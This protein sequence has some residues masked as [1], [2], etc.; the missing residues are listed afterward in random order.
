MNAGVGADGHETEK[1]VYLMPF[2]TAT[3]RKFVPVPSK[4][5]G[6]SNPLKFEITPSG[7]LAGIWLAIRGNIAGTLSNPNALGKASI[8]RQVRGFVNTGVDLFQ[9]SGPGYHYL[10]RNHIEDYKDPVPSSDGRSAVAAGD[11]NLDMFIPIALSAID[12]RGLLNLQSDELV[13]T[14][15]VEFEADANIATGITGHTCTVTPYLEIFTMPPDREDRPPFNTVQQII[16]E[17]RVVSAAGD[18]PYKWPTGN[19]YLQLLLGLGFGVSGADDWSKIIV[20]AQQTDRMYE[21]D[22]KGLDLEY[23]RWHGAARIVG[24]IPLDFVGSDGLGLYGGDRDLI[25][26]QLATDLMAIITATASGTLY[27]MRRQLVA[28]E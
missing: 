5:K 4:D 18:V 21:Y 19:A 13:L 7:I 9:F 23:G 8:I 1:E 15:H 20:K 17:T 3:R 2:Q 26:A 14:V 22:P 16:E 28:V 6:T 12:Q 27:A 24:T 25:F 10:L 11:Y